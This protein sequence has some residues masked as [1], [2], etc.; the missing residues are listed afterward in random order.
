MTSDAPR[1]IDVAVVGGGPA[2]LIAAQRLAQAGRS[3]VVFEKMPTFGRKF[4]MAGR[5]GL[6][7]THSEDFERFAARYGPREAVLRPMLEAFT[8][9]DLVAWAKDLGQETFVGASGRVFPKAMKASPL[10][11]AWLARLEGLGVSLR[12]RSAW[13][14]WSEDG[15]LLVEGPDGRE[16]WRPRATILALGG[17]S[18]PKLGS[19]AAWTET[20][21]GQGADVAPFAPANC[22]FEVS[23]SEIFR[24]RFAGEPL[25]NVRLTCDGRQARGD[26]MVAG[27]GIEGGAVYA[28]GPAPREAIARDG[29]AVLTIDLRPD[30]PAE[31]LER[32]LS[33][34]RGGQSLANHLRKAL[35]LS[36]VEVN[37]L[38]EAHGLD[39][40]SEPAALAAAI[41]AG[42]IRLTAARPLDRAISAA[43][44]VTFDSLDGL[45]LRSRPDV[46]LAGEML[47]WEA[48]TGGYLLQACFATGVAA[49]RA[50]NERLAG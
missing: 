21:E 48:P 27:Y 40:P 33:G 42:P 46:F 3:V 35:K 16:T 14:G 47:D 37:L 5:G 12:T 44:G 19:D 28:L 34:A 22:G 7:L 32:R 31:T 18:W 4:L 26:A 11:R 13:A 29:A 6:N 49:A 43:G 38:R 50:V 20:L 36:P 15:A 41:K 25:K 1:I 10:L 9:T 2:G 30:L 24:D 45:A 8:P 17:A 39:L 23:W